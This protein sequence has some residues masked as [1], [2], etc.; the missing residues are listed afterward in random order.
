MTDFARAAGSKGPCRPRPGP[1]Y[2]SDRFQVVPAGVLVYIKK[3]TLY[4]IAQLA[5]LG[6]ARFFVIGVSMHAPA[7]QHLRVMAVAAMLLVADVAWRRH[8][9]DARRAVNPPR[10]LR[11]PRP[12][13]RHAPG[14]A[15]R[16]P[17]PQARIRLR[18]VETGRAVA[19]TLSDG[20][21]PLP[22]RRR[23]PGRLRRRTA[24]D[25]G[26][27]PRGRRSLRRLWPAVRRRR[28]C[29][30]ARR[31]RGS[32]VSSAMRRRRRSL[33]PRLWGSRL[34]APTGV[35]QVLSRR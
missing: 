27:G 23:R 1:C 11:R 19:R 12:G 25:R 28:S 34:L 2:K 35:Q 26:Q 21:R 4:T 22:V 13:H 6:P 9:S 3:L 7:G 15:T 29:D 16:S 5:K 33:P 24:L 10:R 20:R 18:N 14:R 30:W 17:I 31:R 8:R 32:R